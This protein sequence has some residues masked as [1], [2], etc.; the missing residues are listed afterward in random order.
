M[1]RDLTP[2]EDPSTPPDDAEL[3][4]L[5]RAV[6]E[7]WQRPPQR[8]DQPTW[9]ERVDVSR[10]ASRRSGGRRWI[11][12]VAEAGVLAVVATVVLALGAVFLTSPGRNGTIGSNPQTNP[13]EGASPTG[14]GETPS[15]APAP[16]PLPA[17]VV[18][19]DLPSVTSV[20]LQGSGGYRLADLSK[21]TLGPK[22][23]WD[24]SGWNTL[25]ARAG[26]GWVCV[27]GSFTPGKGGRGSDELAISLNAV[28]A[29]GASVGSG[30]VRTLLSGLDPSQPVT[31]ETQTVDLRAF[32]SPDGRYA[33]IGWSVRS[34]TGWHAGVDVADLASLQVVDRLALP[35]LPAPASAVRRTV[36]RLAPLVD[37][38]AG[39][40]TALITV[41]WW[42]DDVL[43][44]N[45]PQ[46]T[47]RWSATFE[48]GALGE[49][50]SAG[51]RSDADCYEW[52]HGL[53]DSGS[54]YVGCIMNSSGTV[55]VERY[56]LTGTEI[57][58][59][60]VGRFTGY[61]AFAARPDHRL[62]LW[63]PQ[64]HTLTS[65]DLLTGATSSL[66]VP[67]TAGIDGPLDVASAFGRAIGSWLTPSARAKIML[68]PA[69]AVSP[70]GTRL[71][72][73]GIEATPS[74][75]GG[76]A[77]V[78]AFDISGDEIVLAGHWPPNADYVSLAVSGDG[79]F[80]YAAGMGGVDVE[81]LQVPDVK[82]S[83]T[84][85]DATDGSIRLIAGQLEGSELLFAHP[86][87]R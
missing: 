79:A 17:L 1:E 83:V 35:D 86:V 6:A 56:D 75:L 16:S 32:A 59:A 29:T 19:G 14:L 66:K 18:N 5:V 37:S 84:V 44:A 54:F 43:N 41:N 52:E 51:A 9:R 67:D 27:C 25:L 11:G 48:G 70:D 87:V 8:L 34:T 22:L 33:F 58:G 76:S 24:S 74:E 38:L 4:A 57:D 23:P 12:R 13:T 26:G 21:G 46:G 36:V 71:Y 73:I 65:Y 78:F 50:V 62:F 47:D 64:S 45:P 82:P 7:D 81:G 20:L 53:I 85:F 80:V 60:E 2:R 3:G 72:A 77:G 42:V 68:Q 61:G 39:V 63:D 69:M 49:P 28:D 55:R 15:V 40:D 31:S 10:R 30:D